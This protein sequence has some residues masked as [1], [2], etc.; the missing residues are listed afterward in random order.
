MTIEFSPED[1]RIAK[2]EAERRI[3]ERIAH[4]ALVSVEVI[5]HNFPQDTDETEQ[6]AS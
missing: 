6:K 4:P 1:H 2:E 5:E 3:K